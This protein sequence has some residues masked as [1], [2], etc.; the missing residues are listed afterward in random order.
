MAND[1]RLRDYLKRVS[2]DLHDTRRRLRAAEERGREPIAVVAMS[3]RF[4]GGVHSPEDLWELVAEG[5]DAIGEWPTDRGWD[6]DGLYDPD[7]DHPGTAYARQ[8]GFLH[9]AADF[10]AEFF[11]ISPREAVTMDPQQ[12]LLLEAAWEVFERAGFDP[13]TL[14]GSRTGVFAGSM[15]HDYGVRLRPIPKGTGGYL[16]NDSVGSLVS[17]RVAYALGLE[18]P[19]VTVDTAC[20][21][22]LVALHQACQALRNGECETAL[23]GGVTVMATPWLFVEISRQ[24]GLA[25][26]GRSKAFAAAADGAGFSEGVGVLLLER[27]S[28]ALANGHP[29]QAVVRGSAVNQDGASNG[30]SAPNGPSQ[31]RVIREALRSAGLSPAEVDAVEA[32]GTGT[33]LGDPIEAQALI[34]AYGQ[35]RPAARPLLLGSLKSNIGHAQA[36][37]GVAGVIKMVQAMRHGQ[38][39]RTLHVDAPT[40]HV[41]WSTG[42]VELLTEHRPWPETGRPRRAGVSSFGISGTNAHVILEQPPV[43][44]EPPAERPPAP[45]ARPGAVLPWT[46]SARSAPALRDQAARLRERVAADPELD[47]A[48]VGYSLAVSRTLFE[49]RAVVVAADRAGFLDGLTAVAAGTPAPHVVRGT[50]AATGG[51]TAFVFPG[52][53]S[54]WPGMAAELLADAPAYAEQAAACAAALEPYLDWPVLDVLRGTATNGT[55]AQASG[56]PP[57]SRVDVVQ[58]V[59][60]TVMVSLAALWQ[61]HGVRPSAVVGHSQGEIAAAYVAGAL[62]LEDAARIVALRSQAWLG[63]AGRGGMLSTALP[64]AEARRRLGRWGDRLSVAAVNAPSATTISGDPEALEELR[65]ELDADGVHA[66]RIPGVDTA[67][68]SA[69]VDA[70]RE[71]LL[72]ELAPVAP[73]PADIPFYSTVTGG[74]LDTTALDAAYWYRNMRDPVEFESAVRALQA[75]GHRRYVETSP[76]P[77]LRPALQDT[78]AD[79]DGPGIGG[80]A[81]VGTL[82]RDEGGTRRFL[83]SLAELHVAGPG[84]DLAPL[85]PGARR[86]DLPTYPFQRRRHWPE[87]TAQA[88]DVAAAGL[89]DPGH[90]LLGA[91]VALADGD[92]LLFTGRLS[93]RRHPW[94]ADHA[95]NGTVL[96][97]GTAFLDIAARAGAETGCDLVEELVLETPLPIPADAEPRLQVRVGAPDPSGRRPLELHA[98]RED[99]PGAPWTRHATGTLAPGAAAPPPDLAPW[100]PTGAEPVDIDG[101]YDRFADGG[102]HYGPAFRGLRAVWR[103]GDE[104]FADVRLPDGPRRTAAGTESAHGFDLHPALLDAALHALEPTGLVTDAGPGRVPLPFSWSRVALHATGAAQLRVRLAPAGPDAIAVAV[105]DATGAPVATAESLVVRPV[106]ADRLAAAPAGD[107]LLR[108]DWPRLAEAPAA[109]PAPG[110]Y[111]LLGADPLGLGDRLRADGADVRRYPDPGALA[112]DLAA[113][114]P[115]PGTVLYPVAAAGGDPAA[116]VRDLLRRVLET[117]RAWTADD[118]LADRP[119]TVA[120]RDAVAAAPGDRTDP[121]AAAVWGLVRSAQAEHPGR[122]VLVDLDAHA[123]S[124]AALPAA[125]AA[126]EPQLAIR[127]GTTFI[128]RLARA[129]PGTALT[130]PEDAAAWRLAVT[131][132]GTP[133][134]LRLLACDAADRPLA[135]GEV[136]IA[137]RAAGLNFRDVLFALGLAVGE[138]DIGGEGAGVVVETGPGVTGLAPGDRVLGVFPGAFGPLAV[139]DHRMVAPMPAGWT[140]AQ[141]AAVPIA[142]LTAYHGLVDLAGLRAGEAVLVHAAAG[143]VGTAAVQLARHL[144]ADVYATAA[145]A[146]WPALRAAGL[147]DAHIAS[148]RSLDFA[149]AVLTATGGRGVDVVLNSLAHEYVDASL[150]T[151]PHGGRFLE[152][153]KTD[154]RAPDDVAAAHPGVRYQAYDLFDADPDRIHR[155]LG[156]I[157][158]LFR[159]GALRLPDVATWDV[160][161]APEAFRYMSQA[162]HIGKIVLTVPP[163]PRTDGTVLV[164]GGTGALGGLIARHLAAQGVRHLLLTSRTGGTADGAAELTTELAALGAQVTVAACD[165]ADRAALERLLAAVPADRP[166]TGVVHTAGVL[167]DGVLQALTPERLDRVLRPKVDGALHLHELTRGLDLSMFVLFSSGAA[168]FGPA[169]QGNYAAANAFCEALARHRRALG[170][171]ATALGWGLW[172]RRSALT[173]RLTD[174]DL[175]R[176]ARGGGG[177]LETGEALAIFDATRTGP[178]PVLLPVR[179][180]APALRAQAT[181]GTLA[182]VLR[183]LVRGP[184]RRSA[185]DA[186]AGTSGATF[187]QRLARLAAA[188]RDAIL[189]DL[190]REHASA[191]LGHADAGAVEADRAFKEL[192]FDSLT[193]LELRNR[194]NTATGLRLPATLV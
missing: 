115:A 36:A 160:R 186:R 143:G 29:V 136:R 158:D 147:D 92:G 67:G 16:S 80:T 72:A 59:L 56:P 191:V 138:G 181:A 17:G 34:A 120:T 89:D 155:M 9:D 132:P 178:D 170:L 119:L 128:P 169:G 129:L 180:D 38:L 188:D 177:A 103:R 18:G 88:A 182:P 149:D 130:P 171:P 33:R 127:A 41:D 10:D 96:L 19:A 126:A 3:C 42:A 97:P 25:G 109:A 58:P 69:Q 53:G 70:L 54:Q 57:L 134:D 150:R 79:A 1:D 23:A 167:D 122:C 162:R 101:L 93:P 47:P 133:D 71:R 98:R 159:Q 14:R 114:T 153:G 44:D 148:S 64:A 7:P 52:Q 26:D 81:I 11:G 137:V 35:D 49:H 28:D 141:A 140:F 145:P 194:L 108:L 190:V 55:G 161:H 117:L 104:V 116:D 185:R 87:P 151:L 73:R 163:A 68:H 6:A 40:P 189:L 135:D 83:T 66:R 113:G 78:L 91:A 152:M 168:T 5:R 94:L 15:Y 166:L 131:D 156:H 24:R 100:P 102:I 8:G 172:R 22:S 187:T 4:P 107:A 157:L 164:T 111:A 146:K 63:L 13:R 118:R 179:L 61:R 77:V 144:G 27:L 48:D 121:V 51:R 2:A 84:L 110:R 37:A 105:A 30:F 43:R 125:L 50:P 192:G 86:V 106:A 75:D 46:V 142:Y 193:A 165:V 76:H 82:R 32:H 39:P 45:A 112:A 95:V 173:G 62:S 31:E 176:M 174:A 124:A 184:A 123:E 60:F 74:R 183:G 85:F 65:A 12:R 21:S 139:A 90:P 20:S 99:D 175:A 154:R